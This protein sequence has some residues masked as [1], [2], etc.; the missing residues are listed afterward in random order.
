MT[1]DADDYFKCEVVGEKITPNIILVQ[2]LAPDPNQLVLK[3][4]R[5]STKFVDFLKFQNERRFY[6]HL[7]KME[8]VHMRAP[9][10]YKMVPG[11]SLFMEYIK[12]TVI[13]DFRC[14][15]FVASYVEFHHQEIPL[16]PVIDFFNQTFRGFDYKIAGVAVLTISR[17]ESSQLAWR[18][19][20]TYRSFK[21]AQPKMS[22]RYW[23]HGDLHHRNVLRTDEGYLYMIDFENC[24]FTR[25]W[26]ICEIFG[27]CIQC[28]EY[29]IKF[30]PELFKMYWNA[31]PK[32]SPIFQLDLELQLEF[33]MLRKAIHVILQSKYPFRKNYYKQFLE[34]KLQRSEFH[35]WSSSVLSKLMN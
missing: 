23:Q 34:Q 4:N 15:Q 1:T 32:N 5:K 12:G 16:E 11:Q 27:E 26:P 33:A 30:N 25:R 17:K 7:S 31:L 22:T 20:K 3:K 35:K 6:D 13:E 2:G 29:G 24:F 9:D 14:P 21:Y 8:C 19:A 28:D 18:I 10:M